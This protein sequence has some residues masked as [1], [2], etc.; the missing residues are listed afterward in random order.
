M[1]FERAARAGAAGDPGLSE[2]GSGPPSPLGLRRDDFRVAKIGSRA[3]ETRWVVPLGCVA[4]CRA[5]P[6]VFTRPV[7]DR[8]ARIGQGRCYRRFQAAEPPGRLSAVA[9]CRCY[10][11]ERP[12]FVDPAVFAGNVGAVRFALALSAAA[13]PW[14]PSRA[15]KLGSLLGDDRL[16]LFIAATPPRRSRSA[17]FKVSDVSETSRVR[18]EGLCASFGRVRIDF[19]ARADFEGRERDLVWDRCRTHIAPAGGRGRAKR[20]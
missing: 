8:L 7:V 19:G 10:A 5:T 4:R 16:S 17:R 9:T 1:R 13:Y 6:R 15:P 20:G 11:H 14:G 12:P 2:V 18:T 3:R